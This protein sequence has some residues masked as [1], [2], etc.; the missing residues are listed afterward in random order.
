MM[1]ALP[2]YQAVS[3]ALSLLASLGGAGESHGMLCALFSAEVKLKQQAWVDSLLNGHIEQGQI[4]AETAYRV[5]QQLYQATAEAFQ[6][7]DFSLPLLLPE[8]D[9]PLEARIDALSEWCE[10]YLTGLHL[11]GL[12][13]EKNKNPEMQSAFS[14]LLAVSQVELTLEDEADPQTETRYVELCEFVKAAVLFIAGEL[15]HTFGSHEN[16]SIH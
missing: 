4:E 7:D 6:A 13:I 11:L 5:L 9:A 10:G 16:Q 1:A 3:D 12:D 8:D 15:H 2:S 14:D